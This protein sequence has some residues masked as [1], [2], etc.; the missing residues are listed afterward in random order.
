MTIRGRQVRLDTRSVSHFDYGYA[1]SAR[2]A[3]GITAERLVVLTSPKL[4]RDTMAALL[5]RHEVEAEL[6]WSRAT[7]ATDRGL[8]AAMGRT[9]GQDLP[10]K[11][12]GPVELREQR[13]R[14]E[15]IYLS[16]RNCDDPQ[17]K[18][19]AAQA[20]A[21]LPQLQLRYEQSQQAEPWMRQATEVFAEGRVAEGL[22][23]YRRRGLVHR[24][25]QDW[26]AVDA[27][28]SSWQSRCCDP[29]GAQ[30]IM[31]A[32]SRKDVT[33]LN[34]LA[35]DELRYR[36]QLGQDHQLQTAYGTRD[37]AVGDLLVFCRSDR[38]L[39]VRNGT[40]GTVK[41]VQGSTVE[42]SVAGR[43]VSV[44][45]GQFNH[46]EH[47]Y[48][49]TPYGAARV[50]ADSV[51][52]LATEHFDR[53]IARTAFTRHG[54]H[55]EVH[56]SE[57]TFA[58]ESVLM[59]VLARE[60]EHPVAETQ[61]GLTALR[62]RMRRYACLVRQ[63]PDAGGQASNAEVELARQQLPA[64]RR[65]LAA[66]TPDRPVKRAAGAP[67]RTSA[68]GPLRDKNAMRQRSWSKRVYLS[69]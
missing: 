16:G 13:A 49:L 51:L 1:V 15:A 65:R 55:L 20:E 25:A 61:L 4:D 5:G 43:R 46:L 56:W 39:G 41:A 29:D 48:A 33:L 42:M 17:K 30:S 14:A 53:H 12:L 47:G 7:F 69:P 63:A 62:R 68:Q 31:L 52:V 58:G 18:R 50:Q 28:A 26:Q 21:L 66:M 10:A 32:Y 59:D 40:F 23:P 6:H 35:R 60:K 67:E 19:Q 3:G 34:T 37:I 11:Y 57:A 36:G 54:R 44:D 27:L 8:A 24:H 9:H 45:L 64:L 38:G 22:E 2:Q